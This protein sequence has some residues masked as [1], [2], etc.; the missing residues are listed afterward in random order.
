MIL[1]P[2]ELSLATRFRGPLEEGRRCSGGIFKKKLYEKWFF[3][4]G[5]L[6]HWKLF[7]YF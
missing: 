2:L 7:I 4:S 3:T 5:H 1:L 6:K